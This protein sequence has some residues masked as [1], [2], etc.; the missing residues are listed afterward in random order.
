MNKARIA[1]AGA[2]YIGLAHIAVAQKS[3]T[4]TLSAVVDPAPAAESV[5]AKA[6]VPL[7]ESLE[8]L[9]DRDRPDGVILATPNQLHVEHALQCIDASHHHAGPTFAARRIA[10]P[11]R[12]GAPIDS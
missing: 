2:G 9:F 10:R 1:V 5:A 6:G 3:P 11:I 4:C 12:G 8:Q 7:F